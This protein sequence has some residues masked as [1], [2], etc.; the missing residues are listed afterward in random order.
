MTEK[1]TCYQCGDD[2]LDAIRI[3]SNASI[4]AYAEK[5]IAEANAKFY[6]ENALTTPTNTVSDWDNLVSSE[7][8][9]GTEEVMDALAATEPQETD[10]IKA[11]VD[12]SPKPE[13]QADKAVEPKAEKA[14]ADVKPAKTVAKDKAATSKE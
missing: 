8:A 10:D 12:A 6:A 3:A 13:G 2:D 5:E 9:V 1:R 4:R 7:T 14:E 11:K